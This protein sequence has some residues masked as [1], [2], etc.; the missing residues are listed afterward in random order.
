MSRQGSP[1]DLARPRSGVHGGRERSRC[2]A[3]PFGRDRKERLPPSPTSGE[4]GRSGRGV[5]SCRRAGAAEAAAFEEPAYEL[6]VD[7]P[8]S[9]VTAS[10]S[11]SRRR[12]RTRRPPRSGCR[13]SCGRRGSAMVPIEAKCPLPR[14]EL[15]LGR[16]LRGRCGGVFPRREG[17]RKTRSGWSEG[18]DFS[19]HHPTL[20]PHGHAG[21]GLVRARTHRHPRQ[22]KSGPW[23]QCV[24]RSSVITDSGQT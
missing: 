23:V 11:P 8:S 7:D 16:R 3:G 19:P 4:V 2:P 15:P 17:S 14:A 22:M 24:F 5:L 9:R 12:A 18:R 21:V 1:K 13:S 10:G 20:T 6:S